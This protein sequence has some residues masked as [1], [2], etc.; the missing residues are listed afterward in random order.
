MCFLKNWI[1]HLQNSKDFLGE[2]ADN[3]GEHVP[4]ELQENA[5]LYVLSLRFHEDPQ[6]SFHSLTKLR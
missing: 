4:H 6:K 1:E 5:N 2:Q 3:L